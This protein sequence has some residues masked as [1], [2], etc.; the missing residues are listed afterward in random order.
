VSF[1]KLASSGQV[2][3]AYGDPYLADDFRHHNP[4]FPG[5]TDA[6][7][8]AMKQTPKSIP[9]RY[10][11]SSA[12]SKTETFVAVHARTRLEPGEPELAAVHVFVRE[13]PNRRAVGC[14]RPRP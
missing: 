6:L 9:M 7:A 4:R 1:L 14:C 11:R 13:R 2:D 12:P 5:E 10:T 8:R 3:Q